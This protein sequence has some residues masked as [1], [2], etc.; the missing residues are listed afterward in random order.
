MDLD[1]IQSFQSGD[2]EEIVRVF[3]AAFG[4]ADYYFPRSVSSWFWRYVQRPGFDPE[5]ILM[6]RKEN[7]LVAALS[8]TY[9]TMMVNSK[10][11]KIALIDDVSTNPQ[12]QKQG[13]ATALLKHAI[14]RAEEV[15]CLGIHL[16]ADPE[17]SAIRIY[18][19]VGFEVVT[20]CV[21][22]LSVLKHRR[23]ARLGKR[24]QAVPLLALSL[25]DVYKRA[26]I[27]KS[28]CQV[29][30]VEG[31]TAG[32][33]ALRAQNEFELP[34]GTLLLDAEYVRWMT[35]QR[36]DGALEVASIT[37]D[38]EFSGMLT[39]SSSDFSGPRKKDR[40]AV[41]GNLTL[42]ESMQTKNAIAAALHSVKGTAKNILDC[43]MVSM[44]VDQ[45]DEPLRHACK[46]AGF[47]E[48]G[49][50]ASMFHPLNKPENL[51]E[52]REGVWSQPVETTF[53]NP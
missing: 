4:K 32:D 30:I 16:S 17:G 36:P 9:G 25:L 47:M 53:S 42:S 24:H 31:R 35:D 33:V 43:P 44:F 26:R 37:K 34:N 52:I 45:R 6:I 41:I 48:I 29:E 27:D 46:K 40:M 28:L 15:G 21:N 10:P 11:R 51:D 12:W 49:K 39:V 20:F 7:T 22:M 50:S 2:E 8:M 19:N 3:E 1:K 23:A 13:F 5:S 38:N 14:V 18:K